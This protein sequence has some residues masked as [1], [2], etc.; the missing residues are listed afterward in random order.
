MPVDGHA[1]VDDQSRMRKH[2]RVKHRWLRRAAVDRPGGTQPTSRRRTDTDKTR[3]AAEN[4]R[5]R[6]RSANG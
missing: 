6:G 1:V 5:Q 2:R 4:T 3:G